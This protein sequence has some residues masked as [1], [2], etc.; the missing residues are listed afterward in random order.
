M[1]GW[2]ANALPLVAPPGWVLTP[3]CVGPPAVTL[4]GDEVAPVRPAALNVSVYDPIAP[5]MPRPE[6]VATPAAS[7]ATVNVPVSDAPA[8]M[9]TET[10]TPAWLTALPPPSRSCTAGGVASVLP[11][12]TVEE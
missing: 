10:F 11:L 3:S 12:A 4:I 8:P 9:D 6:K 5:E 1:A 2:V 7:V